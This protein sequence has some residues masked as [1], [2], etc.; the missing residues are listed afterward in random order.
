MGTALLHNKLVTCLKFSE[1]H[2]GGLKYKLIEVQ[3]KLIF[4]VNLI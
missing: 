4:M 1:S 2:N 3:I